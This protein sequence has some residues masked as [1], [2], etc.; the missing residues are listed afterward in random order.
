MRTQNN[1]DIDVPLQ[2]DLPPVGAAS[3]FI[4][5]A[6]ETS[7]FDM[8]TVVGNHKRLIGLVSLICTVVSLIIVFLVPN[9]YTAGCLLLPPQQDSSTATALL[10]T[11]TGGGGGGGGAM[12]S[13]AGTL[14]LKN[15]ADLYVSLLKSRTVEDAVIRRFDL[16]SRYKTGTM[17]KTRDRLEKYFEI[18]SS[19][20]DGLV[21]LTVEDVDPKRAAEMA[22]GYVEEYQKFSGTLAVTEASQ[23]RLFF[24]NQLKEARAKLTDAEE[25][26]KTGQQDSGLLQLDSQAKMLIETVAYL[27]AEITAKQVQIRAMRT[28]ETGENPEMTIAK[29]ELAGL[30]SQ[31]KQFGGNAADPES[32]LV[33]TGGKIPQRGLDY[34]RKL[35]DV[36]YAETV[37]E[38]IGK[39][40]EIAKLDEAREGNQIQVVDAAVVPDQKSFP[41]RLLIVAIA[42]VLSALLASLYVLIRESINNSSQNPEDGKRLE[43]FAAA[44]RFR[45]P[46]PGPPPAG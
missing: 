33:V 17:V 16:K 46:N 36:K 21:K 31:L 28:Y 30:Q 43:L 2:G 42:M 20:K 11:I 10:S 35:R 29:E 44:W 13:I 5:A 26:M 7:L 27:R 9:H 34:V 41:P 38:L 18:E 19:P 24:D 45:S 25:N 8:M 40:F 6:G 14:G 23:R 22:N 12:G 39:Q 37:F 1:E 15:P 3:R 32:D 4:P